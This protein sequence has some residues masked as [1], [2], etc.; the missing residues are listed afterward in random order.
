MAGGK[1]GGAETAFVDMCVAMH[2][3]G[4][5]LQVITRKNDQRIVR[6]RE[7]GLT[8]HTLPFGGIIDLYTKK[9]I[10][11]IIKNF[12]PDI[13]QTWMSR[14]AAKTPNWK[15]LRT[16]KR[17]HTVARVGG[18]YDIKKYYHSMD[19]FVAVSPWLK[20]YIEQADIAPEKVR[21]LNNFAETETDIIPVKRQ[22]YN[23]PQDA[24]V[25]LSLGRYHHNKALD[26]LINAVKDIDNA[27]LWLA[28]D[29]PL[30]EQLQNQ[31]KELGIEKRVKFLGWVD[32]RAALL[33]AA[34]ICAFPS[35]IEPFGTVFLQAWA[36]KTP[37]IVSD[38]DGPKQFCTDQKDC[39]MVPKN[40]A[41]ALHDAIV[42]LQ[43]DNV[44]NL[45]LVNDG[46]QNYLENFTKDK[47]VASYLNY[48]T[49]IMVDKNA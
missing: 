35:R 24:T 38:A 19:Y 32:N 22:D 13:V 5:E 47:A 48:Y 31:A 14:A 29:G 36:N 15:S 8:V 21:Q 12:E 43:Q 6:L 3:A 17:F 33:Q 4:Q 27:Y 2:E 16:A 11:R 1:S 23:T 26:V 37:V 9:A 28:G 25:I 20:T 46:Y 45:K 39:L 10:G 42:K 7:A 18:T 41:N 40:D 44:L 49:D 30:K 34:D